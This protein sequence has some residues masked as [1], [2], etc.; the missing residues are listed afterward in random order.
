MTK[1]YEIFISISLCMVLM[2]THTQT[3]ESETKTFQR[4]SQIL[5]LVLLLPIAFFFVRLGVSQSI[6]LFVSF[7]PNMPKHTDPF[8]LGTTVL[9]DLLRL[10][11][12]HLI[13]ILIRELKQETKSFEVFLSIALLMAAFGLGMGLTAVY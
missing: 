1:T 4:M 12:C 7:L 8:F 2:T 6:M 5:A 11:L 10:L 13:L 3:V 9:S